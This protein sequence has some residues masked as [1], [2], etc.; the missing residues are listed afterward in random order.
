MVIPPPTPNAPPK[1]IILRRILLQRHT[2]HRRRLHNILIR[3]RQP[4]I[5]L[6]PAAKHARRTRA[7]AH[8]AQPTRTP[9]PNCF[10]THVPRVIGIRRRREPGSRDRHSGRTRD[11][12]RAAVVVLAVH[13]ASRA[14]GAVRDVECRVLRVHNG[15]LLSWGHVAVGVCRTGGAGFGIG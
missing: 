6:R 3:L 9:R 5:P 15:R 13:G 1:I 12:V 8:D 11:Q 10:Q 4:A 14:G 7:A 2:H